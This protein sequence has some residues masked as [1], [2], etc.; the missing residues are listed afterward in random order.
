MIQV[1]VVV[2]TLYTRP[3]YLEA[4]IASVICQKG[5][6]D[7]R[8]LVGCPLSKFKVVQER[9][10]SVAEILAE[11]DH[12]GLANKLDF[13]LRAAPQSAK[14][15]TWLGD[16]DLLLPGSLSATVAALEANPDC[17]L[18]YGA[19]DYINITGQILGHNP[20]GQWATKII[21]F[22]PQLIPQPGSLFRRESFLEAGGLNDDFKL[23]FDFDFFIRLRK[24]GDFK[25]LN[26]TLAQFR[27]HPDSLSVR[28]R[29]KSAFEASKVRKQNY[30]LVA[31]L[32]WPIWEPV[33]IL[34][35]W[36]VGKLVSLKSRF[37]KLSK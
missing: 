11:P 1:A 29:L 27:W 21:S 25:H 15:L 6:F 8:I 24:T 9:F 31:K 19:C 5:D 22:G 13:F 16:D 35:T 3:E 2:P 14:Y 12:G 28:R 32:L 36:L 23:A 4:T 34:I 18:V 7:L 33:V 26:R 20:S 17:V 30:K 37:R 10:G